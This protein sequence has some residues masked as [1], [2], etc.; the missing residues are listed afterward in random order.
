[1][2]KRFI[3][4]FVLM[5]IF[6]M[7]YQFFFYKPPKRP[8]GT[9]KKVTETKTADSS[10]TPPVEKLIDENPVVVVSPLYEVKIS[11]KGALVTGYKL[12]KYR[13]ALGRPVE[14]IPAGYGLLDVV[15]D[16]LH[17]KDL[18]FT[19]LFDT[20]RVEDEA[21]LTLTAV[22]GEDTLRKTFRFLEN[23]YLIDISLAPGDTFNLLFS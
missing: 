1:M 20:L 5:M 19:S 6:L 12:K 14:L 8:V 15:S 10:L 9:V 23:S 7:M 21:V 3:L 11:R 17:W 2:S 22:S 4:T 16:G 13:D 18:N